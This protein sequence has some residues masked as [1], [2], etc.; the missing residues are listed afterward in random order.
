MGQSA[1]VSA[2]VAGLVGGLHCFAMCGGYVA[3]VS[4]SG[5]TG[6]PLVPARTLAFR[7]AIAHAGRLATYAI[8]GAIVGAL[9]GIALSTEWTSAQRALYV[10]ANALLL[11]LAFALA[12]GR[13]PF[14]VFE[15]AGLRLYRALLPGVWATLRGGGVASRLA[16]G[17]LW[18]MT[19]CAL[20]YGVL[21]L[22]M[23]SG[24]AADGAL[25][26]LAFGAGTLPNLAFAGAMLGAAR[27]VLQRPIARHVAA[28]VVAAFGIAGLYRVLFVADALAHG[29][30]C[31][32]P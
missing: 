5:A 31:L 12:R 8:A 9:G 6:Q 29:P 20:V 14:A 30:F 16:L 7:Q 21:P 23:F 10:V 18:G 3:A 22:A 17:V 4:A 32:V 15:S 24:S 26:M 28:I 2:L 1:L 11:V 19:P 13:S 27:R 25:V